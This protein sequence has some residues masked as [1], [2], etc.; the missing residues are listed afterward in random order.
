MRKIA[1]VSKKNIG[2]VYQVSLTKM[3]TFGTEATLYEAIHSFIYIENI[4]HC[5]KNGQYANEKNVSFICSSNRPNKLKNKLAKNVSKKKLNPVRLNKFNLISID[6]F[7]LIYRC[8]LDT[9][10]TVYLVSIVFT[11]NDISFLAFVS[12]FLNT[13]QHFISSNV[14]YCPANVCN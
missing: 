11:N 1:S 6:F 4:L 2:F 3:N 13:L 14:L 8:I 5:L 7:L 10:C 12:F 9:V